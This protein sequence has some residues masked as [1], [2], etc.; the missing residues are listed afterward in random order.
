ML[1]QPGVLPSVF[2]PT[3]LLATPLGACRLA[4]AELLEVLVESAP[5]LHG[6]LIKHHA[7]QACTDLVFEY[8]MNNMLHGCYARM[9]PILLRNPV[10]CRHLM[11]DI[12][13]PQ[14]IVAANGQ[15]L[16]GLSGHLTL[17]GNA[18]CEA[19]QAGNAELEAATDG[20]EGWLDFV[21]VDLEERNEIDRFLLGGLSV[22]QLKTEIERFESGMDGL[23]TMDSVDA[24]GFARPESYGM[25]DIVETPAA[26]QGRRGSGLG[27]REDGGFFLDDDFE[28]TPETEG[29]AAEAAPDAAAESQPM[30]QNGLPANKC[31]G[32]V[33][34]ESAS[35]AQEGNDAAA[36]PPSN[37]HAME[38]ASSEVD[39]DGLM[40]S[41]ASKASPSP[42]LSHGTAD[43]NHAEGANCV[44]GDGTEGGRTEAADADVGDPEGDQKCNNGGGDGGAGGA[45]AAADDMA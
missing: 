19:I 15:E 4:T 9:V 24:S 35:A 31:A 28:A 44:K 27:D 42:G 16:N 25:P 7:L 39:G 20:T 34:Q 17:M 1:Q 13:L 29:A 43:S 45:G 3:Y 38:A 37:G 6:A 33:L 41:D 36:C 2:G 5:Q 32:G 21:L 40:A 14:R 11:N 26:A 30:D 10:L 22:T 8:D 18:I 12:K 23:Q